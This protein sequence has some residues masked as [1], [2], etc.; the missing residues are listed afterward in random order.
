MGRVNKERA[1]CVVGSR[2][3]RSEGEDAA[4]GARGGESDRGSR[5]VRTSTVPYRRNF[6]WVR[7]GPPSHF[8]NH[9]EQKDTVFKNSFETVSSSFLPV[10]S[11]SVDTCLFLMHL[12][13]TETTFHPL[14]ND[15]ST[16][17]TCCTTQKA[18]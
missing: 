11:S 7:N 17:H 13:A 2:S 10:F 3:T 1:V 15:L 8:G 6:Q 18:I 9:G 12:G 4:V 5:L 14:K 16:K